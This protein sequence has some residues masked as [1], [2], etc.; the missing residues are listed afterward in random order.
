M[1]AFESSPPPPSVCS[2][3]LKMPL[4][5]VCPIYFSKDMNKLT[6]IKQRH[7]LAA[8]DDAVTYTR[9]HTAK[10]S[11]ELMGEGGGVG[12]IV[13]NQLVHSVSAIK[14]ITGISASALH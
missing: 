8:N 13:G 14:Q 12:G 11:D 4:Q 1:D 6:V 2:C 10:K 5:K 9:N 3:F 7:I